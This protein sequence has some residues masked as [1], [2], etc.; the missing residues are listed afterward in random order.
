MR[1]HRK[2]MEEDLAVLKQLQEEEEVPY[3]FLFQME[4]LVRTDVLGQEEEDNE[5]IAE[6]PGPPKPKT[7]LV[8][9]GD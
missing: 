8:Q 4:K 6:D 9:L 2:K 1:D 5:D 3:W 7:R